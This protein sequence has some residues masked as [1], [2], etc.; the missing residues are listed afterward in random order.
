MSAPETQALW[1]RLKTAGLVADDTPPAH[2]ASSPWFVRVMLGFAGWIGAVFL[3]IFVGVGFR[4]VMDSAAASFIAGLLACTAAGALF[5]AKPDSDFATQF[6]LAVS[7]AGQ[8]LVLFGISRAMHNQMSTV[9]LGMAAFQLVLFIAIPNLV[10]RVWTSWTGAC[11][12]VF[13]LVD[14]H[15]QSYATGLLALACAW[16]WLNEFHYARHGTMLRAGGYG[17]VLALMGAMGMA[18]AMTGAW[19]WRTGNQDSE[20]NLWLGAALGGIALLWA[21]WRLLAREAVEPASGAGW[22]LLAAAAILAIATLKAPGLAP[23]TLILL[24]GYGNG[25]RVLAGLGVA[26]LLSYLSFYYYSLEATL[27][28]KSVL[29]AVTGVALLAARLILQR[30]WPAP[31]QEDRHA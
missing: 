12:I 18:A 7:L 30:S 15:L 21:V 22:R 19:L 8:A 9:A 28:H 3:L 23:A 2:I 6:G 5:R 31:Q 17:L 1:L 11:A 13:A 20:I 16:V 27:L 14:W 4:F 24:L 29:M 25:N 26:A 10:H